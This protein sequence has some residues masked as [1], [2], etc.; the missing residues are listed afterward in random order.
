MIA[1]YPVGDSEPI[2]PAMTRALRHLVAHF[3]EQPSLETMAEAAGMSPFHFQRTFKAWAG[4]SPKRF[5]QFVTVGHAKDLLADD[6]SVLD[7]ALET[8]LSGPSR[9]H[10]LF[11]ACEAMTPGEYKGGGRAL[12]VRW[13]VHDGPLGPALVGATARGLC[14]LSFVEEE[15]ETAARALAALAAEWPAAALIH[16][17]AATRPLADRA[18]SLDH[19]SAQGDGPLKLHLDGTNF[20]IQVWRA[21]LQIPS[22]VIVSYGDIAQAIGQPNAVRAVGQACSANR[23]SYVIPCHRVIRKSGAVH[24]YRWSVARKRALIA[25]ENRNRLAAD[26]T[27]AAADVPADRAPPAQPR[28]S[29]SPSTSAMP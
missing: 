24:G 6:A 8:G 12:T 14:W 9:L 5:I 16:D 18:F 2:H 28:V 4:I 1:L 20:Q 25:L 27:D 22:G 13:G 21:L 15:D 26:G 3:R 23:I 7:A 29:A 11:V 19:D 10:D 17:P